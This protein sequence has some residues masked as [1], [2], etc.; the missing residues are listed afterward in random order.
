MLD[1]KFAK[2]GRTYTSDDRPH[3][4]RL[5]EFGMVQSAEMH[6]MPTEKGNAWVAALCAVRPPLDGVP[7]EAKTLPSEEEMRELI[8][9]RGWRESDH[10]IGV[11]RHDRPKAVRWWRLASAYN[12]QKKWDEEIV[13]MAAT[14][15]LPSP[16]IFPSSPSSSNRVPRPSWRE[17]VRLASVRAKERGGERA[18][19][20]AAMRSEAMSVEPFETPERPKP[21][22]NFYCDCQHA[23]LVAKGDGF[24]SVTLFL[25]EGADDAFRIREAVAE[26]LKNDG[27]LVSE[28]HLVDSEAGRV[29]SGLGIDISW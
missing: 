23:I 2:L 9:Q 29:A 27:F 13:A 4:R 10:K 3:I 19:N 12:I 22:A 26:R 25:P 8:L 5:Q 28:A 7:P 18:V 20:A 16:E 14:P 6:Y 15:L 21:W 11:F 24:F 17:F 1:A